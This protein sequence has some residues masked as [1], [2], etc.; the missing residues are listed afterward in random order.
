M[1]RITARK[2]RDVDMLKARLDV[3]S[4]EWRTA[5]PDPLTK[6][7]LPTNLTPT[8]KIRKP[9]IK[10]NNVAAT[11]D[12]ATPEIERKIPPTVDGKLGRRKKAKIEKV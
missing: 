10:K 2:R 9:R 5:Q 7:K 1:K 12:P 6:T 3:Y 4:D 11:V 8:G